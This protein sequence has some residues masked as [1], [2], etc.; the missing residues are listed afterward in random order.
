MPTHYST[1]LT[2]VRAGKRSEQTSQGDTKALM[3]DYVV[4][5]ATNPIA[6]LIVLGLLPAGAR[7]QGGRE[8]HSAMGASATGAI[9]LY[10]AS[11]PDLTDLGA[12]VASSDLQ[13]AVTY[14]SAGTNVIGLTEATL[15]YYVTLTPVLLVT[16]VAGAA[17]PAAGTLK[18]HIDY[19]VAH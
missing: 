7:L 14:T 11:G 10:V 18:G 16:T 9:S 19:A 5:A 8:S 4:P 13:A 15:L 1:Q 6:D 12:A 17:F 2:L 3:W